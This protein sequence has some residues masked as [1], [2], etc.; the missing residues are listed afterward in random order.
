LENDLLPVEGGDEGIQSKRGWEVPIVSPNGISPVLFVIQRLAEGV[1][2]TC[3]YAD[4][5]CDDGQHLV[6]PDSLDAVGLA[7][8]ER[9][10][11]NTLAVLFQVSSWPLPSERGMLEVTRI[12]SMAR[13]WRSSLADLW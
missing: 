1:V 2:Y 9:I 4:K 13:N 8:A 10:C 11:L 12:E 5:P 3:Q 6:G 7:C